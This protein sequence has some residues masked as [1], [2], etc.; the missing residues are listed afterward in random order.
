ML[1]FL[2]IDK[3]LSFP[4][5]INLTIKK[6]KSADALPNYGKSSRKYFSSLK[7]GNPDKLYEQQTYLSNDYFWGKQRTEDEIVQYCA[8]MVFPDEEISTAKKRIEVM[9][10]HLPLVVIH[11]FLTDDM[12][13]QIIRAAKENGNMKRSTVGE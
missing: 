4:F 11:D 1:P 12:C 3:V 9:S 8:A 6:N 10:E 7:L 13:E 2:S 5:R